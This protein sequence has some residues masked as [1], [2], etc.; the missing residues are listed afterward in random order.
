MRF[1]YYD[2]LVSEIPNELTLGF[3][4][5]GCTV[6]CP[7]CHSK[8]LWNKKSGSI[9]TLKKICNIIESQKGIS[10]VLFLGGEW[11]Q[12]SLVNSLVL[13]KSKYNLKTALYSGQDLKYFLTKYKLLNNLDYL[14][15]GPY[16]SE[17]GN[18]KNKQTNQR[19][20][21]LENGQIKKDITSLFWR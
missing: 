18:L 20:Y 7:E 6:H 4:I 2:V 16:I 9:L 12:K 8:E 1:L 10:T 21:T 19:L 15:V 5:T 3:S 13:I 17:Y 11:Y 14:K